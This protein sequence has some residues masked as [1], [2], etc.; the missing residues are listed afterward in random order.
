MPLTDISELMERMNVL[1]AA[2]PIEDASAPPQEDKPESLFT[3]PMPCLE[4]APRSFAQV[5]G[6]DGKSMLEQL[7]MDAEGKDDLPMAQLVR[8]LDTGLR[9]GDFDVPAPTKPAPRLGQFV[10]PVV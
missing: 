1:F 6:T 4:N 8:S 3:V 2:A 10:Y 9:A 5:F 7:A